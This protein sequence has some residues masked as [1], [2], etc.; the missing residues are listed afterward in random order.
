MSRVGERARVIYRGHRYPSPGR[1][2]PRQRKLYPGAMLETIA[3]RRLARVG[4]SV[5]S[6]DVNHGVILDDPDEEGT[7]GDGLSAP[8]SGRFADPSRRSLPRSSCPRTGSPGLMP[9]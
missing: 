2:S 9:P 4:M 7:A 6:A 3:Y 1:S 8:K 5:D